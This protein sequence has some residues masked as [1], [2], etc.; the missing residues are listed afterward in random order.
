MSLLI[1][2]LAYLVII[3]V[4][5]RYLNQLPFTLLLLVRIIYIFQCLQVHHCYCRNF[6][7]A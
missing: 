4:T 1:V 6:T 2:F 5:F 3:I 7:T